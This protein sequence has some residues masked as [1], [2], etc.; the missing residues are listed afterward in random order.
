MLFQVLAISA[1][2]SGTAVSWSEIFVSDSRS[3]IAK[4]LFCASATP[5]SLPSTEIITSSISSA[6]L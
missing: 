5:A 6:N 2:T 1:D 4:N 3:L